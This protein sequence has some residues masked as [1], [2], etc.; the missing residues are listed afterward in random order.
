[1][2][3]RLKPVTPKRIS[4]QVFEQIRDLIYSGEINSGEKL[5]PERDLAIAFGVSRTSVRDAI[6]KLVVM[7]LLEQ[8][9]GQGTFV[10]TIPHE[11]NLLATAMEH[12]EASLA[13]L[14][15]VR[16]GMECNAAYLAAER[17]DDRD[18]KMIEQSLEEMT[19][20]MRAGRLGSLADLAFHMAVAYAAKNP[21]Q[22]F[23]M[24]NLY[25]YL[26]AGIEANLTQLYEDPKNIDHTIEQHK[27]LFKAI[28][29]HQ[30]EKAYRA[31]QQHIHYVL[32]FIK[33][34][35]K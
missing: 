21:L 19:T 16:M 27:D 10:K 11:R 31:M 1:M 35:E 28:R 4:D 30:P 32:E 33:E 22:L 18:V 5:M 26:A 8:K 24:K 29:E 25:D 3:V 17:A 15:E 9:Q 7:G 2:A 14:M 23:L 20:D 6:N 34:R 13:D 12:Q